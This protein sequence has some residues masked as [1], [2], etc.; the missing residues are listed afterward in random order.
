MTAQFLIFAL[1]ALATTVAVVL[2]LLRRTGASAV[3]AEY[4]LRVFKDQLAEI[5]RDVERGLLNDAQAASARVEI[6]RRMLAADTEIRGTKAGAAGAGRPLRIGTAV[7]TAILLPVG[8][9]LLYGS[10]GAPGL[11]DQPFAARQAERMGLDTASVESLRQELDALATRLEAEPTD[12]D[13]WLDLAFGRK[14]LEQYDKALTAFDK[15][16]RLGPVPG[17]VWSEVG[18]TQ[19]MTSGGDIPAQAKVAFL[20]AL[21]ADRTD[22]R[23]RY[24]LGLFEVQSG[25]PLAGLAMWRDLSAGSP[26]DAPWMPMLRQRM[27]QV[28]QAEGVMPIAVTPAHPLDLAD[29]SATV[30]VDEGAAMRAEADAGRAPGEGFSGDEQAMVQDMVAGLAERLAD[31]PDDYDGW[32]R[33]G[34]SYMVLGE[35]EK[36]AEAYAAAAKAKPD[37]VQ[38]PFNRAMVLLEVDDGPTQAFFDQVA[39]LQALA[40]DT[41]DAHY[42]GGLAAKLQGDDAE[43]RRLWTLLRDA[44]PEGSDARAAIEAQ[45]RGLDG[46]AG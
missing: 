34:R 37:D 45:L 18:E 38:A 12:Q 46:G 4:D 15:A 16:L 26:P 39:A 1:L 40:P 5:D 7:T 13:G 20:N 32:M 19:V 43:A 11:P 9:V 3:R 33:L 27:A 28:A 17:E 14:Q 31:N 10:L 24:Y 22:P 6:Q 30:A 25:D 23:A 35:A 29:G 2:P 36:A 44:L 42:L 8:A 41:P 21:R